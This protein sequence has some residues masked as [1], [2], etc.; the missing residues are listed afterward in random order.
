[1]IVGMGVVLAASYEAKAFG[2]RTAM[3]GR[4]ALRLCPSAVAVPP[5]MTAYSEASKAVFAVF[6]DTTP[7]VEG[8]SIDEAFLDVGGLR[9][10]VRIAGRDRH[11]A[12]RRGARAGGPADHG[13]RR[14]HEVPRQG[15]ERR[16]PSP[17]GCWSWRRAASWRSCTRSRSSG[18]GASAPR[19]PPS[20][21]TA[22]SRP[23]PTS[24]ASVRA[25]SCRSSVRS[26]GATCTPSPTTVTLAA[27]RSAGAAGRSARSTPSVAAVTVPAPQEDLDAVLVGIVDRVTRRLRA[28]APRRAHGRA[29]AALRRLHPGHPLA[30]D[31]RRRR[32]RPRSCS[33]PPASCSPR[34]CR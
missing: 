30:H 13:G 17:T 5:R 24:L 6:D 21:T 8:I 11:P 9:R 34:R 14:P 18:C 27:S 20:C 2:V 7:L 10:V 4:Q 26:P 22:A 3:G 33:P 31:R 29:A 1:M 19:P 12:A 32:P 25:R 16:R 15:G 28:A 23:S